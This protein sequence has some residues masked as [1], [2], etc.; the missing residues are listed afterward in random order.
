[1]YEGIRTKVDTRIKTGKLSNR[2]KVAILFNF[3]EIVLGYDM[4]CHDHIII[5]LSL[6]QLCIYERFSKTIIKIGEENQAW[7]PHSVS[8]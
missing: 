8:L 7:Y 3:P 6:L 1:M 4:R 2:I 5:S